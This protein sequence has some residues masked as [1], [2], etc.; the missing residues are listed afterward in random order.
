MTA[1]VRLNPLA[2]RI[3]DH[4]EW[5]TLDRL[6]FACELIQADS[7]YAFLG[8]D[9][10]GF[11]S[12]ETAY[13]IWRIEGTG[14]IHPEFVV[15]EG[16]TGELVIAG[17]RKG[18]FGIGH[19]ASVELCGKHQLSWGPKDF[20]GISYRFQSDRGEEL[21]TQRQPIFRYQR[22][23]SRTANYKCADVQLRPAAAHLQETDQMLL[24]VLAQCLDP[25][26]R[27]LGCLPG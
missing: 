4:F 15:K 18:L 2:T 22:W 19:K 1:E 8:Y 17:K 7:R 10:R 3:G 14:G 25:G 23:R 27:P 12:A 11:A 21:I 20:L 6:G 5:W 26:P 13:G 9:P 24:L 16:S